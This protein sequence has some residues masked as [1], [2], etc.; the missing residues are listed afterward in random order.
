[1]SASD[2]GPC[3]LDMKSSHRFMCLNIWCLVGDVLGEIRSIL[4]VELLWRKWVIWSGA[5]EFYSK[6]TSCPLSV[7]HLGMQ[8][9]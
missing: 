8:C 3:D 9:D 7:S 1:M 2:P 4:E 6:S 5:W